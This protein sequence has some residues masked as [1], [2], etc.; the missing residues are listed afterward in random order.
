MDDYEHHTV[1]RLRRRTHQKI[2]GIDPDSDPKRPDETDEE[3]IARWLR[4]HRGK[5]EQNDG[6]G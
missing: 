6:A 5:K 2:R 3:F 1:R 4:E